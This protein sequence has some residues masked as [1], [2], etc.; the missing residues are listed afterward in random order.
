[1]HEFSLVRSLLSQV[2]EIVRSE[3]GGA[4]REI[5]VRCGPLSGIEPLLMQQAF[6]HLRDQWAL[7]DAR[8]HIMEEPLLVRCHRCDAR[9]EPQ[10]F[11]FRCPGCGSA[12][13]VAESGD[14]VIIDSVVVDDSRER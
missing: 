4:V 8:L 5:R 1:M 13:T 9:F 12:E 7:G 2:S 6:D 14:G 10:R 11:Q 3:G